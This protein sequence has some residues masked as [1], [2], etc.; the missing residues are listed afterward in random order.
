[1]SLSSCRRSGV[2]IV[3]FE[4]VIAD[5]GGI[6]SGIIKVLTLNSFMTEAV[7]IQKPVH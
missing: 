5:W 7:I 4:Y 6:I 3:N 2:F 1:M